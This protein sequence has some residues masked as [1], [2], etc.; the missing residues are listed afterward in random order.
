[1]NHHSQ[2]LGPA[3]HLYWLRNHRVEKFEA[4]HDYGQGTRELEARAA[5][6]RE[7]EIMSVTSFSQ[8]IGQVLLVS[9]RNLVIAEILSV[10]QP[11]LFGKL[12]PH[13]TWR[14]LIEPFLRRPPLNAHL[15]IFKT[16][17]RD[18]YVA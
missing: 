10:A 16:N 18:Y 6:S 5:I 13:A 15:R 3:F 14:N 4:A 8:N 1:V 9:R 2:S 12:N 11:H 7:S 17:K